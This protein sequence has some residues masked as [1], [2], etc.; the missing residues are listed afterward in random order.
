ME[1]R[2]SAIVIEATVHAR[3]SSQSALA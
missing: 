2:P 1:L 3:F